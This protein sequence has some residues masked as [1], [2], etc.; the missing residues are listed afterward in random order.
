[1]AM[2]KQTHTLFFTDRAHIPC[3]CGE[4]ASL[5]RRSYSTREQQRQAT[6]QVA[7]AQSSQAALSSRSGQTNREPAL[8]R[9]PAAKAT[10]RWTAKMATLKTA[11][12]PKAARL[13]TPRAHHNCA[14]RKSHPVNRTGHTDREQETRRKTAASPRAPPLCTPS[15]ACA[16]PPGSQSPAAA[17]ASKAHPRTLPQHNTS[18]GTPRLL[19]SQAPAPALQPQPTTRLPPR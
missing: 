8:R 18:P 7:Q 9:L 10:C 5:Q 17:A 13:R 3:R 4:R 11:S 6:I 12:C 15:T 2:A 1:M 16:P 19:E 14:S